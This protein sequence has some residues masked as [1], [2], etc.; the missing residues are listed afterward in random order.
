MEITKALHNDTMTE[1]ELEQLAAKALEL[2]DI[3]LAQN[4]PQEAYITDLKSE[5]TTFKDNMKLLGLSYDFSR[6]VETCSPDY[7]G[8]QQRIFIELYN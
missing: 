1:E 3:Q 7:Y 6:F 2:Y 4:K 5:I 8:Q